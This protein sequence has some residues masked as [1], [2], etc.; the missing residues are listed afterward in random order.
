MIVS[1][2]L[3]ASSNVLK[4]VPIFFLIKVIKQIKVLPS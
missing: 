3:V 4:S 2:L 1:G